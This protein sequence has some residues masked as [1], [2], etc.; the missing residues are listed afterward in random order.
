MMSVMMKHL[1]Y[2]S[3]Y[4]ARKLVQGKE[5]K[6]LNASDPGVKTAQWCVQAVVHFAECL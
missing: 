6:Y 3:P 1:P 5:V 4:I 2:G